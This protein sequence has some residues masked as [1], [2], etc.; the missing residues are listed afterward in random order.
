MRK[1]KILSLKNT[2]W[3]NGKDLDQDENKLLIL[4]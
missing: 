1:N 2:K 3:E 4:I